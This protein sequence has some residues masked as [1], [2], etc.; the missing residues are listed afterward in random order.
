MKLLITIALLLCLLLASS[1]EASG[2]VIQRIDV[3]GLYSIKD[4]ELL[5]ILGIK[6]GDV[7]DPLSVRNGIKMAF[8]KGI[9]EDISVE[10]DDTD[11]THVKIKVKERDIIKNIYITGND[12]LTKKTIKNFLLFKEGQTMRYD[13]IE[14]SMKELKAALSEKG[15]PHADINLQVEKTRKPYRVNLL[16]AINE[17]MPDTIK[18][19]RIYGT[20]EARKLMEISEGDI[21]DQFKLRKDMEDIR[22]YYKK[23]NYLNP[24]VGPYTFS[25]GELGIDVNPGRKLDITFEGNVL[26]NSKTLLKETPFSDAE[27]FRDDLVDEAVSRITSLYYGKGYPFVQVAPVITSSEDSIA[28]H[29]FIF[30]G[31]EV[32]VN[33]ISFTGAT[34]AEKNLE[35]MMSLKEGDLYNPDLVDTDR[36]TLIEF[37]N[38]LGYLNVRIDDVQVKIKDSKADIAITITEG[39]KTH[40]ESIEIKGA[41]LISKEE[42]KKAIRIKAGDPYNEVDLSDARYRVIELYGNYGFTDSRV[43]VKR[44]LSEKGMKV[45]FEIDEGLLTF[46]GKTVISGNTETKHEVIKRE[47]LYKEGEPFNYTPLTRTRQRL[48]KLGLFTDVDI[49]ALEKEGDKKDVHIRVKEGNAG[50]VEFGLGYGDYERY[51]G[52]IDISYRNLF[53]MNRQ[54]S[55]RTEFSSL[56]QRYIVNYLEPYFSGRPVPFRMLFMREDRTEKSMETRE[57]RY[58][59][60]RHTASAGFEK[61]LSER[62][63][64]EIF[65]EFSLVK[66]FEVKP[67]V[68]LTKEDTGTLAISGIRPGIV[69]DTRDNPFDPRKGVLAGVSAKVASGV[70][71]SETDFVKAI[72]HGSIYKELSKRFVLAASLK[73][74]MAQ[75]FDK[76]RILPL[77]ERF[78]LGGRTT[79]RGYE[80]DMLGPKGVDGSP[81]GGNAFVLTNLELRTYLGKS[82]GLVTFLDGGNVWRKT[83]DIK[84]SEMKYTAGMGIRYNTP[85]G[86]VRVDYGHKLQREKGE[87]AGEIHFTIGHAF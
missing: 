1:I 27:D 82:F 26:V 58:K 45:I 56:E 31:D 36:D 11:R 52:S 48:Y 78:F 86:P 24:S 37:Y 7:L 67:D 77:V 4:E 44:E 71:L 38:A 76:T 53:G 25:D 60:T 33:S 35:E 40:I 68:I 39:A 9:F 14:Y 47:L 5:D 12:R 18:S 66:T 84:L 32:T 87:S 70:L 63:K 80:Q 57:T 46:F 61:K 75:G 16:L 19:I 83:S 64:G 79:V 81:T 42:V 2:E 29:F 55:F 74:G 17:G 69:Y 73:S 41:E 62:L 10:L 49:D 85:V 54:I 20:E 8:L 21:Y 28:I 13:L 59:L 6:I 51:R 30:E 23:N 65:Y 3:E 43:D 15:F 34:I 22:A 50:I 72:I